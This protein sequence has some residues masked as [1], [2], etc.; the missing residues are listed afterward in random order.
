MQLTSDKDST[1]EQL[2]S[3]GGGGEEERV[4][5]HSRLPAASDGRAPKRE[6]V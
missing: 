5:L 3:G 4:C 1:D 2:T 6:S